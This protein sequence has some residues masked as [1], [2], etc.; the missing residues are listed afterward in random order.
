MVEHPV[1]HNLYTFSMQSPAYICKILVGAKSCIDQVV[2][3]GVIS[4]GV[5]F[6]YR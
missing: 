2:V 3:P 1:Q 5:R 6:E 4:V